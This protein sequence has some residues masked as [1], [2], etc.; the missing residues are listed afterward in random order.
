MSKSAPVIFLESVCTLAAC[1]ALFVYLSLRSGSPREKYTAV[2]G[3]ITHIGPRFKSLPHSSPGKYRYIQLDGRRP[4]FEIFTGKDWGD[5]SPA[6]E[7]LDALK[8]RDT[9]TIYYDDRH[10]DPDVN[11]LATYV[12]KGGENY[13]K[14]GHAGRPLMIGGAV[15][16]LL[17]IAGLFIL[18][19]LGKIH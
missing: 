15:F 11:R 2:T 10:F 16:C 14:K 1:T 7:R 9:V 6:S 8:A 3:V 19:R 12:D 5:F 18:K 17:S 13:Y 4:V